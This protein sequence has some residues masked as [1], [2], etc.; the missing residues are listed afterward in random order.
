MCEGHVT[1][2]ASIAVVGDG[3]PGSKISKNEMM[4]EERRAWQAYIKEVMLEWETGKLRCSW[5]ETAELW[6]SW[7]TR[8]EYTARPT[9]VLLHC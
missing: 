1:S 3:P 2:N 7:I 6:L 4:A 8:N 5:G 9:A